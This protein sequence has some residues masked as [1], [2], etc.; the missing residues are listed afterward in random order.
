MAQHPP[1]MNQTPY[2]LH[3]GD[4]N[5]EQWLDQEA[6]VWPKDMAFARGARINT[7]SVGIFSWS[8]LEPEEDKYDF[9]WLD[10]VMDML[11]EN[12]IRAVLATPSGARPAWMAE[13]YPEVLRVDEYGRRHAFGARHNHCLTSPVYREKVE[14]I[15]T[16]LAERYK[17]YPALGL[18]H[19]SNE[20]GGMCYCPLCQARFRQWLKARY[21]SV[22]KL[23]QAWWNSFWSHNYSSFDQI[24]PPSPVGEYTSHGL[25]LAWRR[26]T[27]D[28]YVDFYRHEIAPLKRVTPDI[29]CTTNLMHTFEDIDYFSLGRELDVISWDNYPA[30]T[31]DARDADVAAYSAFCHDL[32]RGTGRGKPFLMMESSPSAVNWQKVNRLRPNGLLTLQGLQAVAH[33]SDSVQY[34]QFR[35]GRGS[36]EKFHGA[37]VSHDENPQ[38][39]VYREV[40][41]VGEALERLSAV[42]GSAPENRVAL[43]YDWENRWALEHA[44]FGLAE[45]GYV[46]TVANHHAALYGLGF[47]VDVIDQ[48]CPLEGYRLVAGPMTYMLKPGF[49][50]RVERFVRAGG[51]YVSTYCSGW[52]NEEDLCFMGGFPG[53]LRAAAG[54]WDE[55]TD[56]LDPTQR[57]TIE[58]N[59]RK[60][61]AHGFAAVAHAEGAVALA[62]YADGFYAGELALSVNRLGAGSYYFIAARTGQ[63]FLKEVY[64]LAA[65]DAQVEPVMDNLPH[66]VYAAERVGEQGRFVFVMN[67][68]GEPRALP[69]RPASFEIVRGDLDGDALR[70]PPYGVAVLKRA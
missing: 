60:F 4:Y 11:A 52:V 42:T 54:V 58:W 2:L 59:G 55:E 8:K 64:A 22:D 31:G 39:R 63:D 15:N 5:P 68:L 32:M 10:R 12:G 20:Y 9:S 48:T 3:G 43:V 13:K 65:R 41:K 16:L 21:G 62:R 70:L 1:V 29:K 44:Q 36:S 46:E 6:T 14:K 49:A 67:A 7:L 30:W 19:V 51:V 47:G 24:L 28:Q 50:Q 57:R 23:N 61:E 25:N 66:G 56:A 18:W 17:N 38:N 53:P 69:I 35:K 40:C 34:F 37:V 45:K 27:S 33:G 26:F